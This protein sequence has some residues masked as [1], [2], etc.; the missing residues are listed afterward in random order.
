M[1]QELSKFEQEATKTPIWLP[2]IGV[3]VFFFVVV[4]AV[5]FPGAAPSIPDGG[6][7]QTQ[8]E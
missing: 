8:N 7:V 2:I 3:V 5:L 4:L 1:D 6:A